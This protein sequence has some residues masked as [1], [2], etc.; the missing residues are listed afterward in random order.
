[1]VNVR[2]QKSFEALKVPFMGFRG[3]GIMING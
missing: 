2:N 3:K 1:M